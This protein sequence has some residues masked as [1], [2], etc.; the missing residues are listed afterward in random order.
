MDI[1]KA[2]GLFFEKRDSRCGGA[3]I[4]FVEGHRLDFAGPRDACFIS[5]SDCRFCFFDRHQRRRDGSR[6]CRAGSPMVTGYFS[7]CHA[8]R[9]CLGSFGSLVHSATRLSYGGV[10]FAFPSTRFSIENEKSTR[11]CWFGDWTHLFVHWSDCGHQHW[12]SNWP[13]YRRGD[14]FESNVKS[15][16]QQSYHIASSNSN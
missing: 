15:H 14:V 9:V 6:E 8:V 3:G 5:C 11:C 10:D 4:G 2:I 12:F 7:T 16:P 13:R 1:W